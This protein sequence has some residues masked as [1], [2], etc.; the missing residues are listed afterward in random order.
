MDGM[1]NHCL[2][3]GATQYSDTSKPVSSSRGS[4]RHKAESTLASSQGLR[5]GSRGK[6]QSSKN[7]KNS[8]ILN[9][10]LDS[11]T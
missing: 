1:K 2:S 4:K 6:K 8:Y 9:M 10:Y 5:R 3:S 11:Y 7:S